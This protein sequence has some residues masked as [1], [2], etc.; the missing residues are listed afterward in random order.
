[1]LD[2]Q[3]EE[4]SFEAGV[5]ACGSIFAK[6]MDVL[7][8]GVL[9]SDAQRR[10]LYANRAFFRLW[11]IPPPLAR[12]RDDVK[13]L[14]F[15]ASQLV[16][17]SQFRSEVERMHPSD[18]SSQD[19]LLFKDGRIFSRR[20]VPFIDDSGFRARI[21]IFTDITEARNAERDA[22]TG[23]LN[24]R[25][26]SREFPAFVAAPDPGL[27]KTA[28]ILDLD[29]FKSY[30]D[31]YGHAAGDVVL[32]QTADV[33]SAHINGDGDRVFRIGGEE[34]L[35]AVRTRSEDDA[36]ALFANLLDAISGLGLKHEGNPPGV[37]TASAGLCLFRG[38]RE[39]AE[40]FDV[41]DNALYRAKS[42][43]RNRLAV[44]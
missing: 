30:N 23:L 44:G 3:I 15:V 21:W 32:R 16:D 28:A 22:L 9:V 10:I 33:L 11:R 17:P 40:I 24:R 26:Y 25:A 7:P 36:T 34:F 14:A 8:D 43:G 38:S 5:A 20:S 31:R 41:A 37:V 19:E 29:N 18:L 39:A 4:T 13:L 27:V 2:P 35:V 6:A 12:R 1:M 42:E